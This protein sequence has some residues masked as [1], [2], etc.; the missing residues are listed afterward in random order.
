MHFCTVQIAIAGDIQ[1]V[2][3]RNQYDPVS[4]P[5]LDVLRFVHGEDAVTSIKVIA[6]VDQ[7][8]RDE[9]ERLTLMYGRQP[10]EACFGAR[11]A[12]IELEATD[13]KLEDGFEW[14]NPI[15]NQL[16]T[17]GQPPPEP[18]LPPHATG[19]VRQP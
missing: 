13:V 19:K 7:D 18:E 2:M 4:W 9:R 12:R 6:R 10:I 14:K 15:T 17:V 8:Q 11:N 5:E 1:Q 16:E 3:H